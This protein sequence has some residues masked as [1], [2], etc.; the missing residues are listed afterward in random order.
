L[1]KFSKLQAISL[2]QNG[3]DDEESYKWINYILKK[4]RFVDF[5][6][7][8]IDEDKT[9]GNVPQQVKAIRDQ[10]EGEDS[11]EKQNSDEISPDLKDMYE[12]FSHFLN[13]LN[14]KEEIRT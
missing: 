5:K 14:K 10:I 11:S 13:D 9:V 3:Y 2:K 8:S 4:I 6:A 7:M 1:H 12:H